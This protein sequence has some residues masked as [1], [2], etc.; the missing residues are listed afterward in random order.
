MAMPTPAFCW[1]VSILKQSLSTLRLNLS[2][3]NAYLLVLV[4]VSSVIGTPLIIS[5]P[6]HPLG[7]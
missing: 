4:L 1:I 5:L 2:F 6:G 3:C 7:V